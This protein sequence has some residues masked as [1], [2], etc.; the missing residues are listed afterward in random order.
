MSLKQV[1]SLEAELQSQ[2]CQPLLV[3]AGF[4]GSLLEAIHSGE[5]H[6]KTPVPF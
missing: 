2:L 1:A 5:P 6:I 4:G 3:E